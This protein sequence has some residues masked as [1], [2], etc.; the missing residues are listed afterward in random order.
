MPTDEERLAQFSWSNDLEDDENQ[1]ATELHFSSDEVDS[2]VDI[3]TAYIFKNMSL[4]HFHG[5]DD[6][7]MHFTIPVESTVHILLE[8]RFNEEWTLDS[9]IDMFDV[10]NKSLSDRFNHLNAWNLN[11]MIVDILPSSDRKRLVFSDVLL[12][13]DSLAVDEDVNEICIEIPLKFAAK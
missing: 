10:V 13:D 4:K 3:L 7:G 11:Q 9:R 6:E 2:C 5:I 1:D 12:V 8:S